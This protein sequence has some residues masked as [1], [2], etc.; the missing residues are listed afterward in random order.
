MNV[1]GAEGVDLSI[2]KEDE[3]GIGSQLS[4]FLEAVEGKH[5]GM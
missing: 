4:A 2:A 5:D 1:N 3:V